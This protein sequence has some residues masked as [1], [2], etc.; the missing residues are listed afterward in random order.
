MSFQNKVC[1]ASLLEVGCAHRMA[2]QNNESL[3]CYTAEKYLKNND[4]HTS[5]LETYLEEHLRTRY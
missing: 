3:S 4:V 2:L 5:T 1:V